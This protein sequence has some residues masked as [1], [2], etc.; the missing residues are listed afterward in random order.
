MAAICLIMPMASSSALAQSGESYQQT[1]EMKSTEN[2]APPEKKVAQP[3]IKLMIENIENK[4]NTKKIQIKL[5]RIQDNQP[6]TLNLLKEAHTQKIHLFVIDDTLEDYS[7]IHPQITKDP[8]VFEFEWQP[9]KQGHYRVWA[10]VVP[11]NTNIQEYIV[12]DLTPA[13]N[14][15]SKINRT[16]SMQSGVGNYNF[17]LSF[18]DRNLQVGKPSMGNITIT[19]NQ[20]KP[21]KDLEPIMGAFAHVVGFSEDFKS[22]VHIHPMGNAPSKLTDRGGPT[23]QFHIEPG[24]AGFVRLFAQVKIKG[25]NLYAPFGIMIQPAK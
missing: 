23:L 16:I 6:V 14:I 19:D 7:H 13:K 20:G 2:M 3:T 18:E 4:G 9:Q 5:I 17:K 22:V 15:P 8:G 10:D 24:Q 21:I 11:Q 25:K 12:A 1:T